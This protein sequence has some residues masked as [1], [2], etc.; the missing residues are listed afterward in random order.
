VSHLSLSLRSS[1]RPVDEVLHEIAETV[2]PQFPRHVV[3]TSTA[4]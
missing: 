4:S 2:L 3:S 1:T